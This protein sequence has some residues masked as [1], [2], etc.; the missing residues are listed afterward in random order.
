METH[1][2]ALLETPRHTA[3]SGRSGGRSSHSVAHI[4]PAPTPP[5]PPPPEQPARCGKAGRARAAKQFPNSGAAAVRRVRSGP[6]PRPRQTAPTRRRQRTSP[7]CSGRPE[8][9]PSPATPS[10]RPHD[11]HPRPAPSC[12]HP[13]Q[14]F[15]P[16]NPRVSTRHADSTRLLIPPARVRPPECSAAATVRWLLVLPCCAVLCSANHPPT[17]PHAHARTP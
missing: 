2:A 16:A 4:L 17:Y 5:S 15:V 7:H 13:S 6:E 9:R 12:T 11:L 1:R 3:H 8:L 10:T 14:L